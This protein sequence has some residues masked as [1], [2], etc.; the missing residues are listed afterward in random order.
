MVI[1][2]SMVKAVFGTWLDDNF[3]HTTILNDKDT[4]LIETINAIHKDAGKKPVYVV[5]FEPTSENLSWFL[6]NKANE[7]LMDHCV[8]VSVLRIYETPNCWSDAQLSRP[9]V[10]ALQEKALEFRKIQALAR[11]AMGGK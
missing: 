9:V 2:F 6:L 5:D 7:L 1:D 3:D 4:V 10:N 11:Q 8:V